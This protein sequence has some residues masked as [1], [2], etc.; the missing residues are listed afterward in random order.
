MIQFK[1]LVSLIPVQERRTKNAL[2]HLTLLLEAAQTELARMNKECCSKRTIENLQSR[3]LVLEKLIDEQM[4]IK[5]LQPVFVEPRPVQPPKPKPTPPRPVQPAPIPPVYRQVERVTTG[6]MYRY[7]PTKRGVFTVLGLP[8]NL[9]FVG[10]RVL[11]ELG[12]DL[13]QFLPLVFNVRGPLD[14]ILHSI[15]DYRVEFVGQFNTP[16]IKFTYSTLSAGRLNVFEA[17][18]GIWNRYSTLFPSSSKWSL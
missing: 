12:E 11:S 7:V 14:T 4:K 18:D 3:I 9:K 6:V 1:N 8:K 2:E 17:G 15:M 13:R 16:S 5:T 10:D